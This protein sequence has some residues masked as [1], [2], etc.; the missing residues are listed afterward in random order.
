VKEDSS[1]ARV[2][3]K[4]AEPQALGTYVGRPSRWGNPFEIGK[5]GTREE[6]IEKYRLWLWQQIKSD[7]G[8]QLLA[9]LG[10]S[11]LICWCAPKPCHA[12]VL[13]RALEWVRSQ[14]GI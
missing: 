9:D 14:S 11:D 10:D 7:R 12:D 13:L 8:A 3:N 2:I 6:V 4:H 5:D 1:V